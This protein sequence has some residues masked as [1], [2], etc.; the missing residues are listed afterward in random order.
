[1][2]ISHVYIFYAQEPNCS[3]T[4]KFNFY[5]FYEWN[6]AIVMQSILCHCICFLGLPVTRH[7]KQG[8]LNNRNNS[9][10]ALEANSLKSPGQSWLLPG[11]MR[12]GS[13]PGV[14]PWLVS[15]HCFLCMGLS[16]W[17]KFPL[18]MRI[19]IILD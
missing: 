18:F 14:A 1:M 12:A 4:G 7:H 16:L 6:S 8:G 19:P 17:P 2:I 9:L 10:T 5:L 3:F 11:A 13:V 15:S